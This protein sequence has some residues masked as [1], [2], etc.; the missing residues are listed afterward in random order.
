MACIGTAD[1][2][3]I[4]VRRLHGPADERD[5]RDRCTVHVLVSKTLGP[6]NGPT[7]RRLFQLAGRDR[8][9]I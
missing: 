4:I 7:K 6:L 9:G 5:R 3:A 2:A 1:A 8:R